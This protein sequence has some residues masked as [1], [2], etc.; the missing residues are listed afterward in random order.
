MSPDSQY[1]HIF[2]CFIRIESMSTLNPAN[3]NKFIKTLII[4]N[5]LFIP[6]FLIIV[7]VSFIRSEFGS[8]RYQPND[9]VMTDNLITE[10]GDTLMAQ[11]LIFD[12]PSGIYNS[13]GM[14]IKVSPK[15]YKKPKLK[16][17]S[18]ESSYNMCEM[19]IPGSEEYYVNI[20]FL[21]SKYNFVRKLVEKKASI[22]S[23]YVPEGISNVAVDTTVKNIAYLIAYEDSN[24]DKLIDCDDNYDLFISDL[25]GRNL[26]KVTNDIDIQSFKF[27][28]S[29][30][31]LLIAYTDRNNLPEEHRVKRFGIY[32]IGDHKF[33]VLTGIDKALNDVQKILNNK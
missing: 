32:N 22:T 30:K 10:N 12:S 23:V 14:M 9:P 25:D 28:N 2:C 26:T 8:S 15:T 7:L 20:L 18:R 27:I 29:H 16:S 13:T 11:G 19:A 24:K 6:V 1:R 4:I 3:M 21:D 5:G 33:T 17:L 31:D